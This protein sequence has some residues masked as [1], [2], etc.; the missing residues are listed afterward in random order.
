MADVSKLNDAVTKLS[1]DVDAL[2]ASQA[3]VQPAI[4]SATAAVTAVDDKVVAATK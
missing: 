4:D 2:I 3:A 1:T